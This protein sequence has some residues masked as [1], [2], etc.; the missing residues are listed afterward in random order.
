[1]FGHDSGVVHTS[2]TVHFLIP[3][4]AHVVRRALAMQ[5]VRTRRVRLNIIIVHKS[6]TM[7]SLALINH[8]LNYLTPL[9]NPQELHYRSTCANSRLSSY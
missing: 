1:M 9:V 4:I 5:F 6:S 3:D 8:E 2:E 7:R